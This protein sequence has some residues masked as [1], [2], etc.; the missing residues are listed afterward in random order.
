MNLPFQIIDV[1][2]HFDVGTVQLGLGSEVVSA[3]LGARR[4]EP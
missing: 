1:V 4:V 3:V 2:D